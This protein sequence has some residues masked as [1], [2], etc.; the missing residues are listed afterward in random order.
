M[1]D[2]KFL[3]IY[4]E[5][6]TQVINQTLDKFFNDMDFTQEDSYNYSTKLFKSLLLLR[7]LSC[8]KSEEILCEASPKLK[9]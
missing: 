5:I 6:H 1:M 2:E 7:I 8:F 9:T 4:Y 3:N